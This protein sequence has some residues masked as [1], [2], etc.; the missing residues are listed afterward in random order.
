MQK[1]IL[2]SQL[3]VKDVRQSIQSKVE[4]DMKC[5]SQVSVTSENIFI[6]F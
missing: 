4:S 2:S 6:N 1:A 3:S 5:A